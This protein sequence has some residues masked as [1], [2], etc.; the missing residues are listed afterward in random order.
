MLSRGEIIGPGVGEEAE[1]LRVRNRVF[2]GNDSELL[3]FGLDFEY[4]TF[5]VEKAYGQTG[6]E[7]HLGEE[8]HRKTRSPIERAE[9]V[10]SMLGN[11]KRLVPTQDVDHQLD[12]ARWGDA[13]SAREGLDEV[14]FMLDRRLNIDPVDAIIADE[15]STVEFV[16]AE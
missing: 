14:L 8:L 1:A 15:T 13:Q 12:A 7:E 2:S 4:L 5:V 9:F 6:F 10:Y 11:L 3:A 16:P